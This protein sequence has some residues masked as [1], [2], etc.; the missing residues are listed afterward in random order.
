M[1]KENTLSFYDELISSK[2]Y[3]PIAG[4]KFISPNGGGFLVMKAS[5]CRSDGGYFLTE[6]KYIEN[7]LLKFMEEYFP[8]YVENLH[9]ESYYKQ[10]NTNYIVLLQKYLESKGVD[11][12]MCDAFEQLSYDKELVDNTNYYNHQTTHE[13]LVKHGGDVVETGPTFPKSRTKHPT[14]AGHE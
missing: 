10:L 7:D 14:T 11:Y 13:F 9:N 2:I 4:D 3:L 6:I 5:N 8:F 12:I 1:E